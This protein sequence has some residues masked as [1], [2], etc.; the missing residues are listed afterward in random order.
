[1]ATARVPIE[2]AGYKLATSDI[3]Q[4]SLLRNAA[5]PY[6]WVNSRR[7]A[8]IKFRPEAGGGA[9]VLGP[10]RPVLVQQQTTCG[11]GQIRNF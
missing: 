8:V 7:S 11:L 10:S 9:D 2:K 5:G 3:L 6:K 1:M 4:N